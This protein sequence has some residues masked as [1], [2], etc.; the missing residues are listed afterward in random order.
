MS[1]DNSGKEASEPSTDLKSEAKKFFHRSYYGRTVGRI[2]Q[3]AVISTFLDGPFGQ[4]GLYIAG[5][6][7]T[8]KTAVMTELLLAKDPTTHF[9]VNCIMKGSVKAV[10]QS[11]LKHFKVKSI[12]G[13]HN[14]TLILDEIDFLAEKDLNL[15]SS[16]YSRT[17]LKVIGI[18]NTLD[19]AINKLPST[20]QP[21]SFPPYSIQDITAII[22]S[23]LEMANQKLQLGAIKLLDPLAIELTARKVAAT[24]DLRKALELIQ[25]AIDEAPTP[26][27]STVVLIDLPV[28]LK[29]MEKLLPAASQNIMSK[30]SKLLDQCNL[31][32][33]LIL[34]AMLII[35]KE[36]F[37]ARPTL[38]AVM[39]EY[40]RIASAGKLGES[41][42]RSDFLDA[43][44]N[45]E[46]LGMTRI[47][48]GGTT[49]ASQSGKAVDRWSCKVSVEAD[50]GELN[51][52]MTNGNPLLA[53][54][55]K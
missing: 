48:K 39:Q 50:P 44:A 40:L 6:P 53:A 8:G 1:E 51:V 25:L 17:D 55:I 47:V 37:E 38:T 34:I 24:G 45:L 49:T 9:M 52:C 11:I 54:L 18:A 28:L 35:R 36:R 12:E 14:V 29:T 32:Q 41:L 5:H 2:D 22:A 10:M 43:I 15:V 7:G 3:K 13:L 30:V 20:S 19:L 46:S 27:P 4:K 42:S 33:K 21:L 31:H 23:R 16:L 26:S